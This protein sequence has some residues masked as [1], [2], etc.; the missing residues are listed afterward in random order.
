M[1]VMMYIRFPLSLRNVEDLLHERR[2]NVSHE[3]MRFWWNRFVPK[4]ATHGKMHL[5]P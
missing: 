5:I 4:T 1:A 3:S 2:I